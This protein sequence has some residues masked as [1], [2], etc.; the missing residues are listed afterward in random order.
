MEG[1]WVVGGG[2]GGGIASMG[3]EHLVGRRGEWWDYLLVKFPEL[4]ISS[5]NIPLLILDPDEHL[6][7]VVG[8][9][10]TPL[11]D[12]RRNPHIN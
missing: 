7:D 2:G 5:V 11:L 9:R 10:A 12:D 4:S 3:R 1:G 6:V 8:I